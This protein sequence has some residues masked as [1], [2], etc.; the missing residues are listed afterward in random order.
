MTDGDILDLL[1][2]TGPGLVSIIGG[3]GK[4]TL[5]MAMARAHVA[6]DHTCVTT[7]STRICEPAPGDT[8]AV[9]VG[10]VDDMLPRALALV[11]ARQHITVAREREVS[12]DRVKLRGF[13][14]PCLNRL[15]GLGYATIVEADG[16]AGR[17][18]KAHD[19]WEPAV[20]SRSRLVIYVIG[21]DGV[22][23]PL[24]DEHVHRPALFA[25]RCGLSAGATVTPEA[26]ATV[27]LHPDGPLRVV[28]PRARVVVGITKWE[29]HAVGAATLAG[30]IRR[31]SSRLE[32][33]MLPSLPPLARAR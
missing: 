9:V 5:M 27:L 26:I 1:G 19:T 16:S 17:S 12:E 20:P 15:F 14:L 31:R 10:P 22:G 3:G 25:A 30:A 6:R 24:D 4:T 33:V 28:S 2:A 8:G 21:A 13:A 32:V 7:T 11:R 18:L 29:A 23:A